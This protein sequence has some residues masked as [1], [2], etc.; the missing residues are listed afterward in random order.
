MRASWL[1]IGGRRIKFYRVDP[2]NGRQSINVCTPANRA[3]QYEQ[4]IYFAPGWHVTVPPGRYAT[5]DAFRR[6]MKKRSYRQ[7]LCV[8]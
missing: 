3:G 2:V 1:T 7:S 5:L 4:T 6:A 8:A